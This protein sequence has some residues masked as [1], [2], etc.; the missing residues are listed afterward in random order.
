MIYSKVKIIG[1]G[2]DIVFLKCSVEIDFENRVIIFNSGNYHA[3]IKHTA[4]KTMQDTGDT[5]YI[6]I[7]TDSSELEVYAEK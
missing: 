4:V 3:E 1:A 5:H 2:L 7:Q 6:S